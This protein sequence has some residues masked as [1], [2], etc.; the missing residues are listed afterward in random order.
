MSQA[1]LRPGPWADGT[2]DVEGHRGARGLAPENTLA[3]V[4]AC[5][6]SGASAVEI[7]VRLTADGHIVLWHDP[8]LRPGTCRCTAGDL[9]GARIDAL[10]L[11]QLRTVDIGSTGH[12][13]FPGQRLDP[14]ARFVTLHEVLTVGV[15]LAPQIWWT[16]E[17][18]VDP[19]HPASLA[20]RPALV[21][22][23]LAEIHEHGIAKRCFVHSFDWGV[24]ELASRLD[25]LPLRSALVE[26]GKTYAPG[27]PWLGSVRWEQHREDLPG[28]VAELGACVVGPEYVDV[29]ARLVRR[30]HDLGIAV[31]TWTVNEPADLLRMRDLGVDGIVTDYP[32]RAL[33]L[34][35]AR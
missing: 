1:T 19:G 15:A 24:L 23:V 26:V 25:P 27:T 31:L 9:A 21:E 17:V 4:R 29:D 11:E 6:E 2:I 28:A 33:G 13:R 18:K 34:L 22:G 20:T 14:T 35:R 10:T 16:I 8:V 3:G 32:D 7:D 12:P 30:A 5:I